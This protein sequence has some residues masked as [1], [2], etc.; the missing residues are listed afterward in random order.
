MF[1]Q[2]LAMFVDQMQSVLLVTMKPFASVH[3]DKSVNRTTSRLDALHL[4]PLRPLLKSE[5]FLLSKIFKSCVSLMV[6]KLQFNSEVMMVSFMLKDIVMM[7][8]VEDWLL[9]MILIVLTSKYFL[10]NVDLSMLM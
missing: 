1:I 4:Q 10:A 6:F 2:L 5:P 3:Q 9:Q 8:S 7:Q